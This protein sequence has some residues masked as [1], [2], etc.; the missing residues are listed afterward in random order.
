MPGVPVPTA[1]A[2]RFPVSAL[3]GR[4]ILASPGRFASVCRLRTPDLG[5]RRD[6]F[7]GYAHAPEIVVSRH[8][9]GD[10]PEK[11]GQRF[12]PPASVGPEAVPDRLDLAAQIAERHG[13]TR[14]GSTDRKGGGGRDLS[15][16]L[17]RRSA[18]PVGGEE[19]P[20]CDCG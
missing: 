20:D 14:T 9:V 19:G 16:W 4:E 18:R 11:R 1:M 10:H 2:G 12:G 15:G 17:R 8:V 6:D 5:D 13:P 3:W 7:S